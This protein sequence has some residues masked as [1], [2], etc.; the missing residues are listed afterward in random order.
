MVPRS[1]ALAHGTRLGPYEITAAIGTGG[2]GEVYRARDTRLDRDVAVKV[3]PPDK[4]ADQ[5]AIERFRREA[6]AASA[7][8]HPNVCAVYDLGEH[9]GQ[10]Y[11]V[12]E[13]LEGASL[14]RT[15]E[16]AALDVPRAIDL[17]IGIAEG[18]DAA[19][20]KGIV[21]RDLKPANVFVT[22][23]GHAK[24][25][26]FGVAK[27]ADA[28]DAPTVA[29]LTASGS[30][31]GT[32][33]YMAP[34][35]ARGE[36]VDARTDLFSLGVVFYEMLTRRPA[37]AGSTTAVIFDRL[38]NRQPA[39]VREFNPDVTPEIER[40]LTRLLAKTPDAR[41]QSARDV[42]LD[43]QAARHPTEGRLLRGSG[44]VSR[45]AA[46]GAVL[47]FASLSSDPENVYLAD[48]ITEEVINALGQIRKLR[49][50]GRVSSFAFKGRT[51]DLADV[52]DRLGVANVLTGSVRKM[53]ARLRVTAE[54]V[55]A[56]DGFQLW[57]ERFD[58]TVDDVF[59][60]QDEIASSIA[61]R[62][63]VTFSDAA[64][65]RPRRPTPNLDAYNWYL[66]GR[67]LLNQRGPTVRRALEAFQEARQ[68]DPDFA[69]AHAGLAEAYSVIG[70]YSYLPESRV[71]PMARASAARALQLDPTLAEPHAALQL[72]HFLYEWDWEA[73]RREFDVAM[74]K[75][76]NAI[77]ALT[78]R[79]L[80]LAMVH[81]RFDEALPLSRKVREL[82][83][84]S[85][86]S[87]SL[88]GTVL[89]C[90]GHYEAAIEAV[91][92]ALELHA[93]AWTI[94]RLI[95]MAQSQLDDHD[96]ALRTLGRAI[97]LSER[98]PWSVV[99]MANAA[100]RAGRSDL[101]A[102]WSDVGFALAETR[103]VQPSVLAGLHFIVG[104]P[105]EAFVWLER[106]CVERDL[107]PV[108][109]YF[110][111]HPPAKRDPRWQA[112]LRRIGLTPAPDPH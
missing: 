51:P 18:L 8:S 19:H 72:V 15:L 42:V 28:D 66:K 112:I 1:M 85:P 90:A 31:V 76:P 75:N 81:G 38:L 62:L 74:V 93:G 40:I 36:R 3:L 86:Y 67:Y 102:H 82:D 96:G 9:A 64:D 13:L 54:L 95:G 109:N 17:A 84:L 6:R 37:F 103:Y 106:A 83:P 107:L 65:D 80:E 20:E 32:V 21:H 24:V 47:P 56:S 35:Q 16:A 23:R 30:A 78:Y 41:Y 59:A 45:A 60:I 29:G 55:S 27:L 61:E 111:M 43:L 77:S 14:Q 73:S 71:M 88:L 92:P 91:T 7:F 12:M 89:L 97:D 10:Q 34:E 100:A 79:A 98:H 46:S 57:S 110:P 49:V 105:D 22:T 11:I 44:G 5:G 4:S 26:D 53:G 108:L 25:L 70:F 94:V 50:A 104:R 48:G 52:S 99:S 69:L 58:R 39:P 2:M 87:Q 68:L 101:A 33:A 63:K